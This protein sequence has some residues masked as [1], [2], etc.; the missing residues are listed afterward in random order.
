M[1]YAAAYSYASLTSREREVMALVAAG[2]INAAILE[3][4]SDSLRAF[5]GRVDELF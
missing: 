4:P 2:L 1:S 3:A 5:G